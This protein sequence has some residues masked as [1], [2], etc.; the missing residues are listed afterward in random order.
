MNLL[1]SSSDLRC[2]HASREAGDQ[3]LPPALDFFGS[4]WACNFT[5]LISFSAAAAGGEHTLKTTE[6]SVASCEL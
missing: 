5:F 4:G 1:A 2:S 3:A 6:L